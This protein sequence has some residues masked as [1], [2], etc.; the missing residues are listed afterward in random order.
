MGKTPDNFLVLSD[1]IPKEAIADPHNC[2]LELKI[3]GQVKQKDNT[4]NMI[5]KIN[6]MIDF[7]E[8]DSC[9]ALNEGDMILTG[10]PE[11]ILP[12]NEGDLLEATLYSGGELV[13]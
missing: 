7:I 2:E 1:L 11:G 10:T 8:H 6:Q 13:S 5:F 9:I 12:V 3:N 4:G